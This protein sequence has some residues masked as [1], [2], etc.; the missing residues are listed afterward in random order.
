MGLSLGLVGWRPGT[1]DVGLLVGAGDPAEG[2]DHYELWSAGAGRRTVY[3]L[4]AG[5]G[6]GAIFRADGS[7]LIVSRRLDEAV[8]VDL[9]SGSV[10][11]LPLPAAT[12]PFE[13]GR[14]AASIRLP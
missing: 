5:V 4:G 13:I 6:W 3:T 7:G 1:S 8:I 14:V 12:A 9:A 10:T 11:P 2:P